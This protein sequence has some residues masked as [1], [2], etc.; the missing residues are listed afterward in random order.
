[1]FSI[2]TNSGK[3]I[4]EHSHFQQEYEILLPPGRYFE[5]I[6]KMNPG[7]GLHII[8][9]QEASPP[10][11]MLVDPFD[12]SPVPVV[13]LQSKPV[14]PEPVIPKPVIPKSVIPKPV[15]PKPVI[16]KPVIPKPVIPKPVIPKPVIPKPRK[17]TS[18]D[19]E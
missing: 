19:K 2:H 14:I 17:F 8:D 16:P 6:D 13:L 9:L 18:F 12:L 4:K 7:G 10:F 3:S 11:K 15:T 1:M 5:V